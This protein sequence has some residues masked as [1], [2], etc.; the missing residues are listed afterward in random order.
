MN[1]LLLGDDGNEELFR[2]DPYSPPISISTPS[3]GV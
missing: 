1:M 2:V 3:L